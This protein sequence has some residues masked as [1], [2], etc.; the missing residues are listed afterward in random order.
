MKRLLTLLLPLALVPAWAG[1]FFDDFD[2]EDLGPHWRFG[3]GKGR[4]IYSV[5][6][7]LLEVYT[8]V[9][10]F[11]TNRDRIHAAIDAYND[12]EMRAVVG[13]VPVDS[14]H[15]LTFSA[16]VT[17]GSDLVAAIGYARRQVGGEWVSLV[18][19]TIG[20]GPGTE[21]RAPDSGFHE[22]RV[23]RRGSTFAAFF[24]GERVLEGQGTTREPRTVTLGFGATGATPVDMIV[25]RVSV[26]PEPSSIL[27]VAI[28]LIVAGARRRRTR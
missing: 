22:L 23:E 3:G 4:M 13:W 24:D 12:F 18:S 27:S 15:E 20:D 25:D 19:V 8:V 11:F 9:G 21:F 7:S 26:V 1:G 2:G 28:A 10:P 5:H 16:S 6:D 14:H 17:P